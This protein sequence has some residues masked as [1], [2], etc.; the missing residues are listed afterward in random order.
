MNKKRSAELFEN[1]NCL[2]GLFSRIAGDPGIQSFAGAHDMIERHHRFLK[3]CIRVKSMRIKNIHIVKP[4][5]F[6]ALI[7]TRYQIFA[8]TPL[9]IWTWPHVVT[10]FRGNNQLI[11]VGSQI[12]LQNL[13][14]KLFR[15]SWRRAVIISQIKMS[16]TQIKS[17]TDH[18]ASVLELVDAAKIMPKTQRNRRK[19][20]AGSAYTVVFHALI[21]VF[22]CSVYHAFSYLSTV[23]F[24]SRFTNESL[25]I[26]YPKS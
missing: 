12:L 16:Y 6:Q 4:H 26:S 7:K 22:A 8:G 14:K 13:P 10:C 24:C 21:A 11:P 5:P 25:F 1:G 18:F 23:S 17:S 3:W 2:C 20:K 19:L 9:A 15:R